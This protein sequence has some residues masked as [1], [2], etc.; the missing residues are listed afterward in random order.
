MIWI[1]ILVKGVVQG[2][3]L[4]KSRLYS[5]YSANKELKSY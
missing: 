2:R 5:K 3:I 1:R 4:S